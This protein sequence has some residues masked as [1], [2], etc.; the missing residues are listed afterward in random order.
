MLTAQLNQ[1]G[2][3]NTNLSPFL[4]PDNSPPILNGWI[5]SYR[6]GALL[7]D[8]G[9]KQ[10][11]DTLE[12]GK[13]VTGLYDFT[14][15]PSTQKA[16]ATVNNAGDTALVLKYRDS[17]NW[18]TINTSTTYTGFEDAKTEFETFIGYAFIVGYDAIDD[19]F[20][21]V[22]SLTG[23]TFSTSTNVT[24]MAQGKY[25]I[26]YRDRLYVL[27]CYYSGT[28]YPFRIYF[29]SV[30]SGGA[31]TWTPASD[32]LDVDYGEQIMGAGVNWDRMVIFTENSAY[33]YDQS[34]FKKAFDIGCSNHRTIKTQGAYMVWCDYDN[35]WLS[36]GGQPQPIGGPLI[37]FIRNGNPR[38]FFA[39]IVDRQYK[40]YVGTVTVDSVTYTNC[41]LTFDLGTSQSWWREYADNFTAY[42]AYNKAGKIVQYM[43]AADGEVMEKGK[44]SDTTLV[45]TDD[46]NPISANFELAPIFAE[47]GMALSG[48]NH[49]VAYAKKAKGLKLKYRILDKN[50]RAITPYKKLGELTNYLNTFDIS[51]A[52][53]GIFVQVA[54]SIR[55]RLDIPEYYGHIITTLADA[56]KPY[57]S[58]QKQN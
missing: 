3:A 24:N 34:Q 11:G 45:T 19:V 35:I 33:F 49:L 41:E 10:V 14:Q 1:L 38:D 29:S 17:G 12:A 39:T 21:P 48:V 54:G 22:G 26:R 32:F 31:I 20:L 8:V 58:N 51:M 4:Q 46:G 30:P 52:Q 50:T 7:Q 57:A 56:K 43:G 28:A 16:L 47:N 42:A 55:N 13:D 25:I 5:P 23:T 40:L 27:N 53:S 44:H 6:L 2:G 15:N 18:T 9:Y 37:E 36:T